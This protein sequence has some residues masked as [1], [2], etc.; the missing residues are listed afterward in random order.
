MTGSM[1]AVL[2]RCCYEALGAVDIKTVCLESICDQCRAE[3]LG[4]LV[5]VPLSPPT[6]P[7][8]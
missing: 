4:Y 3:G 8:D 1:Q 6:D 2:C 5:E 7:H